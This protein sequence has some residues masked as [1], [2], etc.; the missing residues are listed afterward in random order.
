M[1]FQKS[2]QFDIRL[3]LF[4]LHQ[5]CLNFQEISLKLLIIKVCLNKRKLKYLSSLFSILSCEHS[6]WIFYTV[7]VSKNSVLKYQS[8]QYVI[9]SVSL[10]FR[11]TE[12]RFVLPIFFPVLVVNPAEKK[13]AKR[14][15]VDWR[16]KLCSFR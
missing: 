2:I 4:R 3:G 7:K 5:L 12:N 13:L 14:T 6:Q 8:I 9:I 15:S 10:A 11:Q 1:N 16:K